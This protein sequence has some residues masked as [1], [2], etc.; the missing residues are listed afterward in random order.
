MITILLMIMAF[1]LGMFAN[2]YL[3]DT[4]QD[5]CPRAYL[6]YN[7]RGSKCDHSDAEWREVYKRT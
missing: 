5:D 6:G 2:S 3:R 7:C 1:I 4:F